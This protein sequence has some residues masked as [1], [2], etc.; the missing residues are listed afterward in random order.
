MNELREKQQNKIIN[1]IKFV[2]VDS[3]GNVEDSDGEQD[4]V[5]IVVSKENAIITLFE[6]S[7]KELWTKQNGSRLA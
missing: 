5:Y 6:E 3:E 1:P 4:P 7:V 2:Y